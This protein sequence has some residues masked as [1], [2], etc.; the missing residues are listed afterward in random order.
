LHGLEIY[1]ENARLG[2]ARA[3]KKKEGGGKVPFFVLFCVICYA[4]CGVRVDDFPGDGEIV[5][6]VGVLVGAGGDACYHSSIV[7]RDYNLDH[8]QA[9]VRSSAS[10]TRLDT[11]DTR[12][13][14]TRVGS[15]F[16]KRLHACKLHS[17]RE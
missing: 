8:V 17:D 3:A 10:L 12:F 5:G 4:G 2:P 1:I 13:L 6:V 16:E 11:L 15:A 9:T 7:R 14:N